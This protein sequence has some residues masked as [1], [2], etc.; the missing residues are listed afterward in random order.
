MRDQ[1]LCRGVTSIEAEDAVASLLFKGPCVITIVNEG[2]S[3]LFFMP[4]PPRSENPGY[5]P[6][7]WL[8]QLIKVQLR[9]L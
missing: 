7:M 6:V 9:I 1:S 4:L 5:T 2:A 8:F 3:S